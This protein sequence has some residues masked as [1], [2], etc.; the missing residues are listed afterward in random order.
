[1]MKLQFD[2]NLEYR[3]HAT[4]AITNIFEGQPLSGSELDFTLIHGSLNLSEN[5]VGNNIILTEE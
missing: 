3:K 4:N 1:M 2:P 5:G